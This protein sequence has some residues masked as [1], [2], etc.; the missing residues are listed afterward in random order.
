MSPLEILAFAA[1][2]LRGHRLRAG[3]CLL[4]VAIGVVESG[5]ARLKLVKVPQLLVGAC[6]LSA[7]GMLLLAR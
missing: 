5:L 4:G 2:A 7:F 1:R 3:L 6:L